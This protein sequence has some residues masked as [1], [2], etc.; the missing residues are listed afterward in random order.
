MIFD[1]NKKPINRRNVIIDTHCFYIWSVNNFSIE[2]IDSD[3]PDIKIYSVS[4]VDQS[5]SETLTDNYGYTIYIP[6]NG[7]SVTIRCKRNSTTIEHNFK[8]ILED[9]YNSEVIESIDDEDWYNGHYKD[10]LINFGLPSFEELKP[11]LHTDKLRSDIIRRLLLDFRSILTSRGTKASIEKFLQFVGYNK[12][13]V[14][15]EAEYKQNQYGESVRTGDYY[16]SVDTWNDGKN[17]GKIT[18]NSKNLPYRPVSD[19]TIESQLIYAISIANKYFTSVE[20]DIVFAGITYSSNIEKYISTTSVINQVYHND[21][22]KLSRIANI[23]ITSKAIGFHEFESDA[24]SHYEKYGLSNFDIVKESIQYNDKLFLSELLCKTRK[25]IT[26]AIFPIDEV[27]TSINDKRLDLKSGYNRIF[28]TFFNVFVGTTSNYNYGLYY[29]NQPLHAKIKIT[30]KNYTISTFESDWFSINLATYGLNLGKY[31]ITE[32]GQYRI[33]ITIKDDYNNSD[34]YSYDLNV[35]YDSEL[36]SFV[37]NSSKVFDTKKI[38]KKLGL[39]VDSP[40]YT[41]NHLETNTI[42]HVLQS[43]PETLDTYFDLTPHIKSKNS[44]EVKSV[45]KYRKYFTLPD[46]NMLNTPNEVTDSIPVRFLSNWLEMIV[47]EGLK[48]LYSKVWNYETSKYEYRLL[49]V[50]E[51]SY[52]GFNWSATY[53]SE[54]YWLKYAIFDGF[55]IVQM[56]DVIHQDTGVKSDYTVL[57][58]LFNGLNMQQNVLELYYKQNGAYIEAVTNNSLVHRLSVNHSWYIQMN[59]P[60]SNETFEDWKKRED[61]VIGTSNRIWNDYKI[62]HRT[63]LDRFY[64]ESNQLA[65]RMIYSPFEMFS[66]HDSSYQMKIGDVITVEPNKRFIANQYDVFWQVIDSFTGSVVMESTD[67]MLKYRI[68]YP[69]VFDI[70][71]NM[72]INGQRYTIRKQSIISSF[73][74]NFNN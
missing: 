26:S 45:S 40:S 6:N 65:Y 16:V 1:I 24:H 51:Q 36:F 19:F 55:I 32:P 66:K 3:S 14:R 64:F 29:F 53:S 31:A 50:E 20:Q 41:S 52:R 33:D 70:V 30:N 12:E 5:V 35:V 54:N 8:L 44:L 62:I 34:T 13:Q 38:N 69:S 18:L 15:V 37:I 10:L 23:N 25:P 72:S 48:P 46:I 7:Q 61:E 68:N 74:I 56:F 60:L 71:Y 2:I 4:D 11:A 17:D 42:Q 67:Y 63:S 73:Q 58:P 47:I 43:L 27:E 28:G 57:I 21:V 59:F 22:F 39:D 49:D 9:E